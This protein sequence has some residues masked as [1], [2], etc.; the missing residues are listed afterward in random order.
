MIWQLH[1][2]FRNKS[3]FFCAQRDINS[4][5]ER[6]KFIKD[7]PKSH[8]LPPHAFWLMCKEGSEHFVNTSLVKDQKR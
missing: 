2:Q 7:T 5:D 4:F 6:K 8:P 1:H 3:T